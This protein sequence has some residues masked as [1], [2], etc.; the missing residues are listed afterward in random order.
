[1]YFGNEKNERVF[2][3]Y[4]THV[5]PDAERLRGKFFEL[6]ESYTDRL[7]AKIHESGTYTSLYSSTN[8]TWVFMSSCENKVV[9][10]SI[11]YEYDPFRGE[12]T[13]LIVNI[14]ASSKDLQRKL[15]STAC[16]ALVHTYNGLVKEVLRIKKDKNLKVVEK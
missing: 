5:T 10:I 7:F 4:E 1:M 8:G 15:K 14:T 9:H 13:D 6:Y 12:P 11:R 2:D 3:F 16:A